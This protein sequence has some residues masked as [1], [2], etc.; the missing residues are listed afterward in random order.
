MKW[1]GLSIGTLTSA[2]SVCPS[3]PSCPAAAADVLAP[4]LYALNAENFLEEE[5][6]MSVQTEKTLSI[7]CLTIC[8]RT[9]HVPVFASADDDEGTDDDAD[10]SDADSHSDSCH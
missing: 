9:V 8:V 6:M 2:L 10:E 4:S 7:C 5:N 1:F 3:E